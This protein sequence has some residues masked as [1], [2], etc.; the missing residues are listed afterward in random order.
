MFGE[1]N[2]KLITLSIIHKVRVNATEVGKPLRFPQLY[3]WQIGPDGL[4][5]SLRRCHL[6]AEHLRD[7]NTNKTEL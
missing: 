1:S 5:Y 2:R 4:S 7:P 6:K 3:L